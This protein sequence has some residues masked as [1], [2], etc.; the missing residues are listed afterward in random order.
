MQKKKGETETKITDGKANT[1]K[2]RNSITTSL[3]RRKGLDNCKLMIFLTLAMKSQGKKL[4]RNLEKRRCLQR[5]T[6]SEH[7]ITGPNVTE[8]HIK[9]GRKD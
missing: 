4:Y 7:L 2:A 5:K 8:S 1:Q 3:K 9:A 6:E